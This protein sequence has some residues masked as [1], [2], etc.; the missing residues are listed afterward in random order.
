MTILAG[1]WSVPARAPGVVKSAVGE[2][3]VVEA[4]GIHEFQG[5]GGQPCNFGPA[6]NAG[7]HEGLHVVTDSSQRNE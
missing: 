5:V 4:G 7:L 1:L 2:V 6:L 3:G